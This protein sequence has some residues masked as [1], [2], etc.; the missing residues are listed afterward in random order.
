MWQSNEDGRLKIELNQCCLLMW[1][2]GLRGQAW[3]LMTYGSKSDAINVGLW[4][5]I[6]N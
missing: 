2:V 1:I 5:L 3:A 6:W 4:L